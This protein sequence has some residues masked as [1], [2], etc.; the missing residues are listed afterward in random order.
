MVDTTGAGDM[1]SAGFLYGL[2]RGFPTQRCAQIGCTAGAAAVRTLGAQLGPSDWQWLY[3]RLH[4]GSAAAAAVRDSAAAVHQELLNCY[5]LIERLGRGA[6]YY[7]S[8]RL[9]HDSKH[10]AAAEVSEAIYGII[11]IVEDCAYCS[12]YSGSNNC[13]D[14]GQGY[15]CCS[16]IVE[17]AR[18]E[19]AR[20][21]RGLLCDWRLTR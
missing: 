16:A 5:A 9:G 14:S 21:H 10:W 8:A 18:P 13:C 4:S 15:S 19:L 17:L 1:F 11:D 6:V 2:M 20:G 7:G 12:A 3:G